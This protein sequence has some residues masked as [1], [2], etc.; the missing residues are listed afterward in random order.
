MV[1]STFIVLCNYHPYLIPEYFNYLPPKAYIFQDFIYLF[2]KQIE[3]GRDTE[4]EAGS[5]PEAQRGTQS[6]V[7]RITPWAEGG[8]KSPSHRGCPKSLYI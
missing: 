1:F 2:E 6:R 8:A 5:T 3:G 7:P 4:G